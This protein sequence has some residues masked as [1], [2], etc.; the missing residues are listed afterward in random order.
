MQAAGLSPRGKQLFVEWPCRLS[1]IR[2][3]YMLG[4]RD[5]V[6]VHN[7][8]RGAARDSASATELLT[9]M[10]PRVEL[11]YPK[12]ISWLRLS[13]KALALI[14]RMHPAIFKAPDPN[15]ARADP[16]AFRQLWSS[17]RSFPIFLP[18][19]SSC[20]QPA[21]LMRCGHFLGA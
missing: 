17:L 14:K 11:P 3:E 18:P 12:F 16:L 8:R 15:V 7:E 1:N 4:V 19:W 20:L 2:E 5:R 10:N 13:E 21:M 6:A 9:S